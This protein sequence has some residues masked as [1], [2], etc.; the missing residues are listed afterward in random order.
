VPVF[1]RPLKVGVV[2][3]V[4]AGVVL[5]LT[6]AIAAFLHQQ[7]G[8]AAVFVAVAVVLAAVAVLIGRGVRW[9]VAVC[10]GALAG[11]LGAIVGTIWELTHGV[12]AVKAQ[13]LQTLG[14]DPITAVAINLIYSSIGFGL[15]CWLA[16]R[17]WSARRQ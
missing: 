3:L 7:Y 4:L 16:W 17:W 6:G 12:A 8:N 15:F 10:F 2:V 14:F 9:A 13:Q 1:H 5:A 11:Q